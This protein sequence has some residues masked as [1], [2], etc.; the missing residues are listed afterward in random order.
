MNL[1]TAETSFKEG[2]KR[3]K[4]GQEGITNIYRKSLR[5][6]GLHDFAPQC[7]KVSVR[8]AEVMLPKL[9]WIQACGNE[10]TDE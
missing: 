5:A 4:H 3:S 2:I 6:A 8:Y 7:E 9:S 1:L 10:F